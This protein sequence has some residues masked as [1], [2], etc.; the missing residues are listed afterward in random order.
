[1][2]YASP[3]ADCTELMLAWLLRRT[4]PTKLLSENTIECEINTIISFF[5]TQNMKRFGVRACKPIAV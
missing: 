4:V 2:K 3:L 1:M 5:A